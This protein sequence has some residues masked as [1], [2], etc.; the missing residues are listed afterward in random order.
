MSLLLECLLLEEQLEVEVLELCSPT[1]LD[2]LECQAVLLLELIMD[3]ALP[4]VAS[5]L[6]EILLK[7][8]V[9]TDLRVVQ[10][11]TTELDQVQQVEIVD[12]LVEL[13]TMECKVWELELWE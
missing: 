9:V 8:L 1:M 6:L 11:D 10:V 13:D 3:S 2:T 5:P 4:W 12:S 7:R